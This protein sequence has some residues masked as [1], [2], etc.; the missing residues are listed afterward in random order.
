M[1][2]LNMNI[3]K[4]L[5]IREESNNLKYPDRSQVYS[6]E[7]DSNGNI[8]NQILDFTITFSK[9]NNLIEKIS[10]NSEGEQTSLEQIKYT[11]SKHNQNS[12]LSSRW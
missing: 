12:N 11:K 4:S 6:Y 10:F 9:K 1:E 2:M 3:M 7:Y 8:I 5:L